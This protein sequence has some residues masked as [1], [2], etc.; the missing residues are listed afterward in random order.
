MP[1]FLFRLLL[2]LLSAFGAPSLVASPELPRIPAHEFVSTNLGVL[3]DQS[4]PVTAALQKAI[5]RVASSG[6]GRLTLAAGT[7]VSGPLTLPSRFDLHLTRG[8]TLRLLPLSPDYPVSG[9]RYLSLLSASRANDLRI[10]GEGMIDGGGAPWWRAFRAKELTPRRPQLVSFERCD[11]VDISG[12]TFRDPPNT[13]V[14]LRLCREVT[15]RDLT[16]DAP[17]DS[18]NTDGLNVSGKNYLFERCRISTGDDNIVILTHS[19]PDW[20]APVCENFLIRDCT[21][22]FGHGLSIGSYT[23]GGIR[24]L[25]AERITFDKTTSGIRLKAGR[26]RGGLVENLVYRDITMRDVKNPVFISSYYPKEPKSPSLDPSAPATEKT[27]R[28]KNILIENLTATGS[29]NS[30]ILWG[31]PE[32]PLEDIVIRQTTIESKRG[33]RFYHA[34]NL[35]IDA[36]LQT[37]A[38]PASDHFPALPKKSP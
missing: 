12:L 37:L 5:D 38:T 27:P 8:A 32:L 26:D 28:W 33:A 24:G 1:P 9:N 15:F 34:G 4:A 2:L 10:S 23:G 13:H 20:P 35:T 16:L 6:G 22:G 19:A 21:L 25:L 3:P 31:L 29:E 11:R 7:Y 17:D 30:F 36:R 14:A 18:P